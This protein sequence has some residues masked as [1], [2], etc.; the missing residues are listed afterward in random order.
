MIDGNVIH[1]SLS[2]PGILDIL[3]DEEQYTSHLGHTAC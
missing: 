1:T 2:V 3:L